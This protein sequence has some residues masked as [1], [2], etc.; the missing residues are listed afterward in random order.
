MGRR[1]HAQRLM[2]WLNG[3]PVAQWDASP[4]V[5][6]LT[7]LPSWLDDERARPLSLSLPLR[8]SAPYRGDVVLNFFDNLLPDSDA[9]RRRMALHFRTGGT[10]P[11]ELL[12]A[13]GRDC[14][15]A[16][17]L[18]PPDAE[19]AGLHRIQGE[20]LSEG[21]VAGLLAASLSDA[22]LGPAAEA[23]D[24]RLSI[25]GAQEKNALLWHAG[26]WHRPVGS[27]P[28]TH[29]LKLPMGLVGHMQ[30]DMRTSVENEWLC[31]RILHAFGLPVAPCG[32]IQFGDYKTLA[33]E[34]FDRRLAPEDRK[35]VV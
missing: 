25:A 3:T 21:D 28:T 5:Q 6:T 24:L 22:P 12:A 16:V 20:P 17:Q 18:L 2:V 19:P 29:I 33:V 30:A 15:G 13:V 14:V 9:I 27:T 35:S 4:S 31:A 8:A 23:H 26:Q 10:A 32:I 34:R 7:Y 11:Y 1:R